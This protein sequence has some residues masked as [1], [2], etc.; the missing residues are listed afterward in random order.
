MQKA[1]A[2]SVTLA[3][4]V[5]LAS[6]R[7][8]FKCNA[9]VVNADLI[10]ATSYSFACSILGVLGTIEPVSDHGVLVLLQAFH[11]SIS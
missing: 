2:A 11:G 3:L 5:P 1:D 8:C 4:S 7:R 6:H 10:G 9:S